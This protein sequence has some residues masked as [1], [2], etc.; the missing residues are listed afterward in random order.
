MVDILKFTRIFIYIFLDSNETGSEEQFE[1]MF[2][3][4]LTSCRNSKIKSL[5]PVNLYFFLCSLLKSKFGKKYESSVIELA[6]LQFSKS[7]SAYALV[8]NFIIDTNYF[9]HL[10]VILFFCLHCNTISQ[11]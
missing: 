1:L 2:D 6:M 10:K 9:S 5:P 8:K 3:T 7:N 11:C 4:L